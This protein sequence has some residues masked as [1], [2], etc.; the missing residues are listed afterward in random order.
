MQ[1]VGQI[2][3][4]QSVSDT[5]VASVK[6]RSGTKISASTDALT[7]VCKTWIH[8]TCMYTM[9]MHVYSG[10]YRCDI[11]L[12][13]TAITLPQV[14]IPIFVPKQA[15]RVIDDLAEVVKLQK[16]HGGWLD[17]MSNV[18]LRRV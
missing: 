8:G 9:H 12:M 4:I 11:V 3:T 17:D 5:K 18:R 15:V 10:R 13:C 14:D 16:E 2:G 1:V 7:K 6:Y